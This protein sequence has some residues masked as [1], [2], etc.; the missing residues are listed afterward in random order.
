MSKKFYGDIELMGGGEVI[1][2]AAER[3]DADPIVEADEEGIIIYNKS[4]KS[5][6]YNNGSTWLVF[7]VSATSSDELIKSLGNNWINEDFS[8]NPT[9]F[10]ALDNFAGLTTT[11]S[12]FDV[13]SQ[14]NTNITEAKTVIT[15][16]GVPLNIDPDN[17]EVR[18]ILYYD[19]IDFVRGTINDLDTLDIDFDTL[20]DTTI[21]SVQDNDTLVYQNNAWVNK[22]TH[23]KFQDLSGTVNIFTVTHE[24]GT[25][26]CNVEVIDMS[27]SPPVR[28]NPAEITSITYTSDSQLSVA[29]AANKAVTILVNGLAIV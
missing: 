10:N 19:G 25:Q 23:H 2:L 20:S 8:F 21:S 12:L 17:L 29:I 7:E 22:K 5:Y 3:V 13:I 1:N 24:L 6:K 27:V 26:L 4:D 16:R 28:I 9:P 11:D 18:N 15:L 14:I